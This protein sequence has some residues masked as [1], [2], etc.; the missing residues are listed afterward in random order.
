MVRKKLIWRHKGKDKFHDCYNLDGEHLGFLQYENV[1]RHM[2]FC[3]YQ[4]EGIRMSPGCLEEVRQK[5]KELIMKTRLSY[6]IHKAIYS[7]DEYVKKNKHSSIM[8]K[9]KMY[10]CNQ[11]VTADKRKMSV[12]WDDVTCKNCLK[13]RQRK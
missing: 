12:K 11:A 3:W 5:Q 8:V 1:G 10:L 4:Y 13:Q 9:K 7:K 6:Q 2:H